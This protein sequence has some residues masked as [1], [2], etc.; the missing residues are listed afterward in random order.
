MC[1]G[2]V[3]QVRNRTS[4]SL[5]WVQPSSIPLNSEEET[6]R[7]THLNRRQRIIATED[8]RRPGHNVPVFPTLIGTL[9]AMSVASAV[10]S[11]I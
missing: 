10:L 9:A 4:R 2:H 5:S 8:D 3:S 11:L 7:S 6:M 1:C